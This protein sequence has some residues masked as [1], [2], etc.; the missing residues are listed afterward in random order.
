MSTA[1]DVLRKLLRDPAAAVGLLIILLLVLVAIFAPLLATHPEAIWDMN[2]RQRLLPPSDAYVFGTDRMGADIYSRILFGARI[3]MVIA[4]V[5]VGVAL[6]IGVPIG[7]ISGWTQNRSEERRVGKE[8]RSR[9][10]P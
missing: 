1:L 5:A 2:P 3:T 4:S 8:C 7:L 6:L 9:W 10:S